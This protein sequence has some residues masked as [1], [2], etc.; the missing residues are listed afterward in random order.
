MEALISS[1]KISTPPR[2]WQGRPRR[3]HGDDLLADERLCYPLHAVP[4]IPTHH[5]L[6][7]KKCPGFRSKLPA[8]RLAKPNRPE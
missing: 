7:G 2:R 8:N 5:F 1:R 4:Y 6:T 3:G